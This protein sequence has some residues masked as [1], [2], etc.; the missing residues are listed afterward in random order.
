MG[1]LMLLSGQAAPIV[2]LESV[3]LF[4]SDQDLT[5]TFGVLSKYAPHLR[6]LA[7][8]TPDFITSALLDSLGDQLPHLEELTCCVFQ[9][10]GSWKWPSSSTQYAA[11]F[12]RLPNLRTLAV[13]HYATYDEING[14]GTPYS[15]VKY[16]MECSEEGLRDRLEFAQS[17]AT[18]CKSLRNILFCPTEQECSYVQVGRNAELN[19]TVRAEGP[20][21]FWQG[22]S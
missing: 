14:D 16:T 9:L 11:S 6:R 19:L 21:L 5:R 22:F 8:T 18:R 17:M 20:M 12:S 1:F 15:P 2:S 10:V 13:N 4:T 7:F 3:G